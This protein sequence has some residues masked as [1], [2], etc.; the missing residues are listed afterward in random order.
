M[1][2]DIDLISIDAEAFANELREYL[3]QRFHIAV[4]IKQVMSSWF[5]HISGAKRK[6][7]GI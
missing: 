3:H 4:R 5:A 1:T 7:I 2:Q 6:A